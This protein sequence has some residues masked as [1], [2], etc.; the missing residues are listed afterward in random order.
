MEKSERSLSVR[1]TKASASA[2]VGEVEP[3]DAPFAGL[4][5]DE[6]ALSCALEKA[7]EQGASKIRHAN[8]VAAIFMDASIVF[9]SFRSLRT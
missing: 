9:R 1:V 3:P 8:A 6:L 7:V 5:P 2:T 4:P